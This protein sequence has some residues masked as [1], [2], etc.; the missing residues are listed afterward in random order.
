MTGRFTGEVFTGE[1]YDD[2]CGGSPRLLFFS[3]VLFVVNF[4]SCRGDYTG[5]EL[6]IRYSR[7]P[8][9]EP[10]LGYYRPVEFITCRGD[11]QER[12]NV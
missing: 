4:I 7:S 6:L 1:E 12:R 8:L 3:F 2:M 9:S 10:K 11:S 5:E